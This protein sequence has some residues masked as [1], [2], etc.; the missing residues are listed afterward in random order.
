MAATAIIYL[1]MTASKALYGY[2]R[3]RMHTMVRGFLV[4]AIFHK[5]TELKI[6]EVDNSASATLMSSDAQHVEQAAAIVY[7]LWIIP[8]EF[9]L[10][11]TLLQR[12][13]GIGCLLPFI[14]VV[15]AFVA[16]FTI[17]RASRSNR[18][19]WMKQIQVRVGST[20]NVISN[21]KSLKISG[22]AKEMSDTIQGLRDVEL[23]SAQVFR[24]FILLA[25]GVSWIPLYISPVFAF[26][27][28]RKGLTTTRIFTTWSYLSLLNSPLTRFF[29]M[30]PRF[31]SALTCV[32]R[33][34][35]FLQLSPVADYRKDMSQRPDSENDTET[36]K[37]RFFNFA[38]SWII[39]DGSFGWKDG[40]HVLRNINIS[41]PN[42]G[43]TLVVGPVASGKSSL[44][45]ALLGEM[46][47]AQGEV[48]FCK[49]KSRVGF[50]DQ[51]PFLPNGSI[52]EIIIAFSDYDEVWY[53]TVLD[54][55]ALIPD[56]ATFEKGDKTKVGTKGTALSGGQ[57]QR[58][59]IAR[60][61]YA[62]PD[63]LMFDDIF[64][65]L[66]Q[67]TEGL[68]FEKMFGAQGVIKRMG[69]PVLL[70]THSIIHLAAADYIIA[71]SA[72][73]TVSEQG[74]HRDLL[75]KEGYVFSLR[76]KSYV[77]G[78]ASAKAEP[79]QEKL[80]KSQTAGEEADLVEDESRQR[81]DL[82]IY[83]YYFSMAGYWT[84]I[85]FVIF[86]T[87]AGFFF[88]FTNV[89]LSLW[90]NY[91]TTHPK[92]GNGQS[93]YLGIYALIQVL[94][95]VP[96]FLFGYVTTVIGAR[97]GRN[98]HIKALNTL[99]G[100]PLTFFTTTDTGITTNRF[101]QDILLLDLDMVFGLFVIAEIAATAGQAIVIA[102]TS[103]YIAIGYP[104]IGALLYCVQRFYL[105][106]SRQL[107]FLDLETK[108]PLL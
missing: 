13:I 53:N 46:P 19:S 100:A 45:K 9:V 35:A 106:T 31:I 93:M 14:I 51:V 32:D 42:K 69:S 105:K 90:S 26:A 107:R 28:A 94:T 6:T 47:N 37:A 76:G 97:T 25:A 1:G 43:L 98:L 59:A 61:L 34:S 72:D 77:D 18:S 48:L 92:Y 54:A 11:L 91:T 80:K 44:C 21:M 82:S 73:G 16:S 33:I 63:L 10:A 88:S 74:T 84:L 38:S 40:K 12:E 36:E 108:S 99:V 7:E 30:L 104:V 52:R 83:R 68:V 66:D 57:R 55:T 22:L 75:E 102:I 58:I 65:G 8:V 56:L 85:P 81:G 15:L 50:C 103:P 3:V 5:T 96:L 86:A 101:A 71:L 87:V 95:I 39:R 70:C 27:V 62:R 4:S 78:H 20:A 89:W 60:A 2:Q 41:I 67:K 29:Q 17:G 24:M 23:E 79:V 49:T 64:S